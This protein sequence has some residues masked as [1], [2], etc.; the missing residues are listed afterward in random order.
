MDLVKLINDAIAKQ[1]ADEPRPYIGASSIGRPCARETWYSFK[2]I[3][4]KK[5][6]SNAQTT[7]DIGKRLETL[8]LD[9]VDL[10]GIIIVRAE[11]DNNFL[12]YQDNEL[13]IF[14]GHLDA[15]I[16]LPNEKPIV[17]EIKTAKNSSFMKFKKVGLFDW[18]P[19]YYAQMQSYMGM[20][21][22]TR[23]AILVI[24]KDTS[25]LHHEWID[26]DLSFY[27]SLREKARLISMCKSP[28]PRINKNPT[29]FICNRCSF[30]EVCH[31]GS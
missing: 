30:K 6:P 26:F 20:T 19:G 7:F 10:A 16:L 22:Y 4:G 9:Y 17:L 24:N 18:S 2:G 1:N 8:L 31:D 12:F 29:Y 23:A 27:E 3:E 25:E 14:Q 11:K 21:G 13:P 28:P 15:I 5:T